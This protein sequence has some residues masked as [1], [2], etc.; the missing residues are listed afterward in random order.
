MS[1]V[2]RITINDGNET[3]VD[4]DTFD[5]YAC[6][7]SD[8]IK[9]VADLANGQLSHGHNKCEKHTICFLDFSCLLS[10]YDS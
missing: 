10:I 2:K 6:H 3:R 5:S 7:K 9:T 4:F 1:C 8:V